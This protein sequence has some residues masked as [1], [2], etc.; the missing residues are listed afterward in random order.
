MLNGNVGLDTKIAHNHHYSKFHD[1]GRTMILYRVAQDHQL[2]LLILL[3]QS[4]VA[5]VG[6][7]LLKT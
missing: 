4:T 2:K 6:K 3:T 5:C 1:R 7:A